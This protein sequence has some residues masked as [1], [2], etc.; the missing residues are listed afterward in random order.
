MVLCY[1]RLQLNKKLAEKYVAQVIDENIEKF[2]N[3]DELRAKLLNEKDLTAAISILAEM[4]DLQNNISWH[5]QGDNLVRD[6]RYAKNPP[7][8]SAESYVIQYLNHTRAAIS[9]TK[10]TQLQVILRKEALEEAQKLLNI[11]DILLLEKNVSKVNTNLAI[12]L[13]KNGIKNADQKIRIAKDFANLQDKHY[14]IT[15]LTKIKDINIVESEIMNLGLTD[16]QRK[17]FKAIEDFKDINDEASMHIELEKENMD[18]FN[19]MN[20][21]EQ[22]Q[23]K[24][25]ASIVLQESHVIPTQLRAYLPLLRNSYTKVISIKKEGEDLE[26]ILESMHSASLSTDTKGDNLTITMENIRQLR[27]FVGH[28]NRIHMNALLSPINIF[29]ADAADDSLVKKAVGNM[30][31]VI[32]TTTPFNFLRKWING[33]GRDLSGVVQVLEEIGLA[34]EKDFPSIGKFLK[35]GDMEFVQEAVTEATKLKKSKK[36]QCLEDCIEAMSD[37]ISL[38][39]NSYMDRDIENI[40]SRISINMKLIT[41]AA[42]KG[43]LGKNLLDLPAINSYCKSGKDRTQTIE[44]GA[45]IK[46][47]NQ[48]LNI[49]DLNDQTKNIKIILS[50]DHAST[51]AGIQGGS[52]GCYGVKAATAQDAGESVFKEVRNYFT[53]RTAMCNRFKVNEIQILNSKRKIKSKNSINK[54]I[55]IKLAAE[56]KGKIEEFKID[57]EE[58]QPLIKKEKNRLRI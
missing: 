13:M 26:E 43:I 6:A 10:D 16:S 31:G 18:W 42:R 35:L 8:I 23:V 25:Y 50:G 11:S 3:I 4:K 29:D 36:K 45:C 17:M 48:A 24:Q 57:N 37:I 55:G 22:E 51:M 21:F 49:S 38:K 19:K 30:F 32:K 39:N 14:H 44:I 56:A 41:Y 20:R 46:A 1:E 58:A 12:K 28:E 15:T 34:I 53:P 7:I 40:N 47:L 9:L 33:G 27:Q 52:I 5:K 2:S 54:M